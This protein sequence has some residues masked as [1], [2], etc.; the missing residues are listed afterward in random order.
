MIDLPGSEAELAAIHAAF[1]ETVTYTGGGLT[2][3]DISAVRSDVPADA[4]AGPG[5][6]ARQISFEVLASAFPAEP[7]NGDT[8]VDATA[9]GWKVIDVT[10][11]RDVAAWSLIVEE[12]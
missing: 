5:S 11:R 1:A 7:A 12:T 4:F 6:T 3:A 2:S 8:L 10:R 9:Q